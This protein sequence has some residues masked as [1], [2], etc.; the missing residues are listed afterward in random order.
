MMTKTGLATPGRHV[1]KALRGWSGFL[2][3]WH[4][5]GN[6]ACRRAR[7]CR[8]NAAVCFPQNFQL[9]PQ[10][11]RDWFIGLMTAKEC[12]VPFDEAIERL[13]RSSCGQA[14]C[15][16]NEAAAGPLREIREASEEATIY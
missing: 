4:P 3:L 12:D 5:C 8:G 11:V 15:D 2:S 10:D 13:D 1:M 7:R 14:F 9:L 6:A 16:W